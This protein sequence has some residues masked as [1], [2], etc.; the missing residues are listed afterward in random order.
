MTNSP[1]ADQWIESY[2]VRWGHDP[3]K[4]GN[5]ESI[6]QNL[7]STNGT[8][9]ATLDELRALAANLAAAGATPFYFV[10]RYQSVDYAFRPGLFRMITSPDDYHFLASCRYITQPHGEAPNVEL[11]LLDYIRKESARITGGQIDDLPG[12]PP[13]APTAPAKVASLL[14][15]DAAKP[16]EADPCPICAVEAAAAAEH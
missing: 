7:V 12:T 2:Q 8:V 3:G 16:A 14:A 1:A 6:A 15:V 4:T 10:V 5:T 11:N 9:Y 13:P